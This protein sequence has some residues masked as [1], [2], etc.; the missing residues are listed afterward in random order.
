MKLLRL[1]LA[2]LASMSL[3]ACSGSFKPG[4]E[5]LNTPPFTESKVEILASAIQEGAPL[6]FITGEPSYREVILPKGTELTITFDAACAAQ[7]PHNV[8]EFL[9]GGGA[10]PASMRLFARKWSLA[11][12]ISSR[13]LKEKMDANPCVIGI[14]ESAEVFLAE[15][16]PD[17]R[18]RFQKHLDR[19]HLDES[20][21]LFYS[22]DLPELAE[23]VVAVIDSGVDYEHEDLRDRMWTNDRGEFGYNFFDENALPMDLHGHGT[24]VAGEIAAQN[25]NGIGIFSPAGHHGKIMALKALGGSGHPRGTQETVANS[26]FYAADNGADIINMSLGGWGFSRTEQ[27]A[28]EYA[29]EKGVFIAA[30]AGNDYSEITWSTPYSPAI[31]GA[32][33]EGM[34]AVGS[35]SVKDGLKSG[36]SN[37][38]N[39]IIEMAAPGS[40][41]VYSLLTRDTY[42]IKDGTSMATP[43]VSGAAALVIGFLKAKERAYTPALIEKIILEGSDTLEELTPYFQRGRS[44]NYLT[45]AE[46]L[47][48]DYDVNVELPEPS[49]PRMDAGILADF[50]RDGSTVYVRGYVC[51]SALEPPGKILVTTGG[52]ATE[53]KVSWDFTFAWQGECLTGN[54]VQHVFTGEHPLGPVPATYQLLTDSAPPKPIKRM[55]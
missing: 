13:A 36:F 26:I 45:L 14:S 23:V 54:I 28:V 29:L 35:V 3:L 1:G 38:S 34:I 33:N 30:A 39:E 20:L 2:L 43:L 37:Y 8:R 48:A 19:T 49:D 6:S 15:T 12:D 53:L 25:H 21:E 51:N 24:F 32:M 7:N 22:P 5:V 31:F 41:G 17:P 42:G 4:H 55:H 52:E 44:L 9:R 47:K 46:K 16:Q 18:R 40:S 27:L 50:V 11:T 10:L